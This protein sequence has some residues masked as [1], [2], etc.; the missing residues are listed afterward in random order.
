MSART[1]L[2]C[3]LWAAAAV[4]VACNVLAAEPTTVG[5]GVAAWP[6]I[7]LL[8]VVEVLARSP[9]PAGWLRWA[10]V[11]G[12]GCVASVAAVASFHHMHEVAASVGESQLVAYLFPLSVDGLAVV[13]SVALL[14]THQLNP[15]PNR[16]PTDLELPPA[17]P[18][19]VEPLTPAAP[20]VDD[21]DSAG[22]VPASVS[23]FV[24]PIGGAPSPVSN[25][26]GDNSNQAHN[27]WR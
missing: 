7:A 10:A 27:Q 13:A 12:A 21:H 4:S 20:E 24:P 18:V 2:L 22:L 23:L 19:A 25:G 26:T 17:T 15:D 9:L 1:R 16:Q 6:P 14:G 5:R 3:V 11:I 8:L